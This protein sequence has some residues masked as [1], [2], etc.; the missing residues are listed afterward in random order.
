M[1]LA[2]DSRTPDTAV[3]GPSFPLAVRLGATALLLATLGWGVQVAWGSDTAEPALV[4]F[5]W[6]EWALVA[7]LALVIVSGWWGIWAGRTRLDGQRIRQTGLWSREVVL[8]EVTQAKLLRLPGLDAVFVPRL[9]L[10]SRGFA[11]STFHAGSPVLVAAFVAFMQQR[12][13]R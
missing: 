11:M 2:P 13:G 12:Q 5:G 1:R 4:A 3:E 7:L 8:A 6:A 9:V 10:R